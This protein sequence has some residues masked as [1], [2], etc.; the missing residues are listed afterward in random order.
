M[1]KRYDIVKFEAV[2]REGEEE[3]YIRY[4]IGQAKTLDSGSIQCYLP[5]GVSMTGKFTL[6]PWKDQAEGEDTEA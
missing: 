5:T 2:K 1:T 6:S 3:R 4:K